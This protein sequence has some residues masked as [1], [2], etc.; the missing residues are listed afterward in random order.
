MLLVCHD[1]VGRL[2]LPAD[3]AAQGPGHPDPPGAGAGALAGRAAERIEQLVTRKVEEKI[4]ENARVEKIESNTR[5]GLTAIF[6]TLVE[7][8][9]D[10]GKE[11]DDIKL[12]LDAIHDLPDGAGPID[13]VKDFGDTAALMLTVASPKIGAARDQ[14]CARRTLQQ[15]IERTRA[16]QRR[17]SERA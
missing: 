13:F 11:F 15:A 17:D 8:T 16:G 4:G 9:R 6:I 12:K 1:G 2:R 7:G 5:T 3:A 10:V 14:R